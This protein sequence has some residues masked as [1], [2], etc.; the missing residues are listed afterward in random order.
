[1]A[2]FYKHIKGIKSDGTVYY[3]DFEAA[4]T[5]SPGTTYM[6]T[7]ELSYEGT[8]GTV[9]DCGNIIT[10]DVLNGHIDHPFMFK[11]TVSFTDPS[12]T[13]PSSDTLDS[14]IET[15][16][17]GN[18]NNRPGTWIHF[19]PNFST[20]SQVNV[21]SPIGGLKWLS[22][23]S[24]P[25]ITVVQKVGSVANNRLLIDNSLSTGSIQMRNK[26]GGYQQT[27][28]ATKDGYMEFTTT[29]VAAVNTAAASFKTNP[30]YIGLSGSGNTGFG[31]MFGTS[32]GTTLANTQAW[33]N[34]P[35]NATYFNATSDKRAKENIRQATFSA[36]DVIQSLPIYN[37][38]YSED[39]THSIGLIAQD[40]QDINLDDFEIV[41]NKEASGENG[42]YM[43]VKESKLVY[44]AW[45]AIQEQQ[46]IIKALKQE[47]EELKKNKKD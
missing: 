2:Y 23:T 30:I 28:E 46:E 17:N 43:S 37:F 39:K 1:M 45:K 14:I 12:K 47:I 9:T 41:A 42:N 7:P 40:A 5:A 21:D 34:I 20:S 31:L 29:K 38:D 13:Y 18:A 8:G 4:E 10:S 15:L 16:Y 33:F 6:N 11:S 44:I 36:L 3:M 35:V 32:S 25:R 27:F 19:K 22:G 24:G 26:G